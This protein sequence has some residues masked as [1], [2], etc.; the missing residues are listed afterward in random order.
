MDFMVREKH[1][2][3]GRNPQTGEALLLRERRVVTCKPAAT[4]R[5]K[6]NPR[7]VDPEKPVAAPRAV[8]RRRN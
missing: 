1:R 4:R 8:K 3:L 5:A 2:R 7:P 6:L